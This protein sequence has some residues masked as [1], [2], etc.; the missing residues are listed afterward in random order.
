MFALL[1]ATKDNEIAAMAGYKP[2]TISRARAGQLG[3]TFVI[4]T[5]YTLQRHAD[6]LAEYGI[7]PTLDELF[8]VVENRPE[9]R[10]A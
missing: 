3:H 7:T 8:E 1:G 2:R 6:R 10:A 9:S 5:V 4:N